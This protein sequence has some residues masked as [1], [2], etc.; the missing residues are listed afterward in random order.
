VVE[1]ISSTEIGV[2]GT[3]IEAGLINE[4]LV[5]SH[6]TVSRIN[7]RQASLEEVFVD[8]TGEGFDVR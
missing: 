8:L 2:K 5:G 1:E 7:E 4:L 3:A 6:F